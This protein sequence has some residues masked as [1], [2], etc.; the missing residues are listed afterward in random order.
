MRV[1]AVRRAGRAPVFN[2][3]VDGSPEF[4]ADGV[5]VHNCDGFRYAVMSAR[6]DWRPWLTTRETPDAGEVLP[7]HRVERMAQVRRRAAGL[8]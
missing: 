6:A 7:T 5:L 1:L 8:S 3:K 4:F 2:L